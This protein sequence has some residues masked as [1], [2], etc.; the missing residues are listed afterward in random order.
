MGEFFLLG[1][2]ASVILYDYAL[3]LTSALLNFGSVEYLLNENERLRVVLLKKNRIF[4]DE[5]LFSPFKYVYNFI[6]QLY[7]GISI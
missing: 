4:T 3:V 7:L 1:L 6:V 5:N 2:M